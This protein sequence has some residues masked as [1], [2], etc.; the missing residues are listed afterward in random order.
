MNKILILIAFLATPQ[1][2]ADPYET[3]Q[4]FTAGD[5]ISAEVLNDILDRIELSLKDIER[6]EMIGTWEV[7]AYYCENSTADP[8]AD[9]VQQGSSATKHWGCL[10]S[11]S[12]NWDGVVSMEG[13]LYGKR[14]DTWTITAVSG[15]DSK[16][17]I[18]S[19]NYNFIYNRGM[20]G[21]EDGY[22]NDGNTHSCVIV[23]GQA[24][25]ACE[26]EFPD[27][28]LDGNHL[29]AYYN[30]QRLSTTRIKLGWAPRRGSGDFNIVIIDKT[31]I[32]PTAPTALSASVA[33]NASAATVTLSWTINGSI[34]TGGVVK[35]KLAF[36]GSWSTL[37][38]P[39]TGSYSDTDIALNN[40]YWYRVFATNAN[41]TS[42]GSNVVKV[43]WYNT[44]PSISVPSV[45]S[46]DENQATTSNF[47]TLN[48]SD[49][50]DHSLTLTLGSQS[51]GNDASDFTLASTL[52]S[53]GE[54]SFN[55]TPDYESPADYDSDNIYDLT[56]TATDGIETV[57]QD[58][59]VVVLNVSD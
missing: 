3:A 17:N 36:D 6:D 54:L 12:F 15:S 2:Y 23:G 56:L 21:G 46:V 58:F 30:L 47:T 38:T 5:V 16:F 35:R 9:D 43:N 39:S 19:T 59:S 11:S 53:N 14:V 8:T 24:L 31:N 29:A 27:I 40:S 51:P 52:A 32:P 49:A 44:P 42:V 55:A 10:Y 20:S 22:V 13:S 4:R 48:V 28:N 7:T 33:G 41:G 45:I 50:D 37:G 25:M 26:L 34:A 1:L 57:S 18:T